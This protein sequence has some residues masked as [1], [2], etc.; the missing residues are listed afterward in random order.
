MVGKTVNW[1]R[2][3]LLTL[4]ETLDYFIQRN[5]NDRYSK[6]LY[7]EIAKNETRLINNPFLGIEVEET[8]YRKLIFDD[9][10]LYYKIIKSKITIVLFWDNR[11]DSKLLE[12]ELLKIK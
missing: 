5:G 12:S 6:K 1:T 2:V 9:Y 3:A 10:S 4:F 7:A 8:N 11:R